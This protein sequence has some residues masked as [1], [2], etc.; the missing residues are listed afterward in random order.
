MCML[1]WTLVG[2]VDL[3]AL[4][5]SFLKN[6]YSMSNS[7]PRDEF[8]HRNTS[9]LFENY[10]LAVKISITK[11]V[12]RL[13]NGRSVGILRTSVNIFYHALDFLLANSSSEV[14]SGKLHV[15]KY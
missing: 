8:F 6:G 10:Y 15:I 13:L 12:F 1:F 7:I 11:N 3:Q 5:K 4:F 9:S 14:V 2:V